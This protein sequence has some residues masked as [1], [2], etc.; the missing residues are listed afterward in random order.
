MNAAVLYL[1]DACYA[2]GPTVDANRE[3]FAATGIELPTD[4]SWTKELCRQLKHVNHTPITVAQLHGKMMQS[5]AD[6]RLAVVPVHSELKPTMEGSIVIAPVRGLTKPYSS[7]APE[8]TTRGLPMVLISVQ[9][10]DMTGSASVEE[11]KNWLTTH[12]PSMTHSVEI[13]VC[14]YHTSFFGVVVLLL[15]I[16]VSVWVC[17]RGD[18]AYCFVRFVT[19]SN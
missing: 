18:P 8:D 5:L 14:G 19:S 1:L 9:L 3:V 2:S 16:P 11:F 6:E 17:L 12:R 4:R 15:T 7:E 10:E 13:E